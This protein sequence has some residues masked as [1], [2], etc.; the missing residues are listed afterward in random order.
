MT[1]DQL[2]IKIDNMQDD[3]SE[4]KELLKTYPVR[5]DRLEQFAKYQKLFMGLY[6]TSFVSLMGILLAGLMGWY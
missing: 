6:I 5:I 1:I 2:S 3:I 4:I